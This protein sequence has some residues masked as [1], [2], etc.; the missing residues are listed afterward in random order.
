[1]AHL[2]AQQEI[3]S[4]PLCFDKCITDVSGGHGLSGVEKNCMRECYL[5]K[6]SIRDDLNMYMLQ[7]AGRSSINAMRERTV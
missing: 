2:K 4:L 7:R 3:E 1:M 6:V 5:K